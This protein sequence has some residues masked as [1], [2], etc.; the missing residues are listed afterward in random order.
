MVLS[1]RA[2]HL[3]SCQPRVTVTPCFVYKVIRD[4]GPN[5][6]GPSRNLESIDHLFIIRDHR[7]HN[8]KQNTTSLSL[9]AGRTVGELT[10][11]TRPYTA[12]G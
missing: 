11:P 5:K 1:E 6:L 10:V 8:C 4:L 7:D 3:L 12:V 9:L 2:V